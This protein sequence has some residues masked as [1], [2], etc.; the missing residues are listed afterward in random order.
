MIRLRCCGA[1]TIFLGAIA[2]WLLVEARA[3]TLVDAVEL[4]AYAGGYDQ[5]C[6]NAVADVGP[7]CYSCV[8]NGNGNYI[9][10][11]SGNTDYKPYY[12][13]GQHP[14]NHLSFEEI[15]CGGDANTYNNSSC[16]GTPIDT[17][18]CGRNYTGAYFLGVDWT[19][20]CP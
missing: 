19:V 11:T 6:V 1:V 4:S 8:S 3:P 17:D 14:A 5:W 13:Q 18:P 9:R 16:M 2:F 12:V 10:C 7:H 15:A 20:N